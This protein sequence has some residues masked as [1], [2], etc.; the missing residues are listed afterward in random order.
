MGAVAGTRGDGE[1]R[2]ATTGTV[3]VAE[4]YRRLGPAPVPADT[5]A[6]G[7]T[8]LLVGDLL[9]RERHPAVVLLALDPA[10]EEEPGPPA[11]IPVPRRRTAEACRTALGAGGLV[12]AGSVLG[13]A[14]LAAAGVGGPIFP[15]QGDD[16]S[17]EI[18]GGGA[19][20]GR[21]GT[22]HGAVTGQTVVSASGLLR[23]AFTSLY[24]Q[25]AP[26][27]PAPRRAAA[28]AAPAAL[29][30]GVPRPRAVTA[31]TSG[32]GTVTGPVARTVAPVTQAAAD[33]VTPVVTTVEPVV[34]PVAAV[35]APAAT[36]VAP[37]AEG[38]ATIVTPVAEVAAPAVVA[39]AAPVEA[40]ARPVV[41]AVAPVVRTAAPVVDALR[42][43]TS[44]VL[45]AAA[46]A[47]GPFAQAAAPALAPLLDA[48]DPV[49]APVVRTAGPVLPVDGTLTT[50]LAVAPQPPTPAAGPTGTALDK[51]TPATAGAESLVTQATVAL[52]AP[53]QAA[54]PV[55]QTLDSAVASAT[56]TTALPVVPP[57]A[58]AGP[59]LPTLPTAP[60]PVVPAQARAAAPAPGA[61]D[62][63]TTRLPVVAPRTS[64]PDKDTTSSPAPDTSPSDDDQA[65]GKDASVG[66]RR[67]D[68]DGAAGGDQ[69][70]NPL[71]E[72]T[73]TL[74]GVL[75]R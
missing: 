35:V 45:D 58:A 56:P 22:A 16:S 72:A 67:T 1:D 65:P 52:A 51:L 60:I 75:G 42:P 54:G 49:V 24:P 14:L 9:R 2:T 57:T 70:G 50:V 74:G 39:V 73:G 13:A 47:V 41:D 6:T 29:Q 27:A 10:G 37:V 55:V 5:A 23:S 66:S 33:A 25:Q 36:A 21:D 3:S 44:P 43:I 38:A 48:V 64:A 20:I 59:L 18:F 8:P 46:P 30:A 68:P 12:V 31:A 17:G 4:L 15:G 53:R 62:P 61:T 32:A 34:A 28:A 11:A 40:V 7:A 63:V 26:T 69:A 71:G 19:S